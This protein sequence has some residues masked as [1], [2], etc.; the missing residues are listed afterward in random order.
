MY[1]CMY[2]CMYV[3]IYIYI[4]T[5]VYTLIM[6]MYMYV[7]IDNMT[8]NHLDHKVIAVLLPYCCMHPGNKSVTTFATPSTK[9]SMQQSSLGI[10][11]WRISWS[12]AKVR[13]SRCSTRNF[14]N[15]AEQPA[16]RRG[17]SCPSLGRA[18]EGAAQP[19][20]IL[21][22]TKRATSVNVLRPPFLDAPRT[23]AC[24]ARRAGRGGSS[25]AA[26]MLYHMI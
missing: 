26:Y 7:I 6:Y 23:P 1:V 24:S 5:H 25:A 20:H 2:V 3:Y 4:Y 8:Q 17:S 12:L 14:R 18:R 10:V 13:S 16:F 15:S 9:T 21:G 19:I 22:G 11:C